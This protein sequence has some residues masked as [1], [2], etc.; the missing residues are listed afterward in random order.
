MS[1]A[2]L[3]KKSWHTTNLKNVEDVWIR[4]EKEKNEARKIKE[5]REKYEEERELE[6]LQ[7]LVDGKKRGLAWMYQGDPGISKHETGEFSV[8]KSKAELE[9]EVN[10]EEFASVSTNERIKPMKPRGPVVDKVD[11]Q[12]KVLED[13]LFH[14]RKKMKVKHDK[15]RNNPIIMAKVKKEKKSRERKRDKKDKKDKKS[16]KSKKS[17]KG[18]KR[19]HM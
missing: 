18:K 10:K 4:E 5:L 6:K 12:A 16:K 15:M 9:R 19:K 11:L 14:I 2:F 7:T 17:K 3:A 13:P 8:E 1:L